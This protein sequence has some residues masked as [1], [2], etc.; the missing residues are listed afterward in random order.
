MIQPLDSSDIAFPCRKI[1]E[2]NRS[3]YGFYQEKNRCL[4]DRDQKQD[5]YQSNVHR[6][7]M[8]GLD[9]YLLI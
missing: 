7:C 9:F 8:H 3:F 1:H 6:R 5:K 2:K 4:E